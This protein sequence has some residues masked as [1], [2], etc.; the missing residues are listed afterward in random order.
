VKQD[1]GWTF[2][3]KSIVKPGSVHSDPIASDRGSLMIEHHKPHSSLPG[4][5]WASSTLDSIV[6]CPATLMLHYL[7]QGLSSSYGRSYV[8]VQ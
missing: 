1:K 8:S 2:T 5:A 6:M 4:A 3:G 7:L